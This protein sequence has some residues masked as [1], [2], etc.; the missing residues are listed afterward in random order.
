MQE[1][2]TTIVARL[3]QT[4]YKDEITKLVANNGEASFKSD[5]T[6]K[7][8]GSLENY[9]PPTP[10][11][12][13]VDLDAPARP[14]GF[15]AYKPL[16]VRFKW[17]NNYA[18]NSW[19]IDGDL[20]NL[21]KPTRYWTIVTDNAGE[22]QNRTEATIIPGSRANT[23]GGRKTEWVILGMT[24]LSQPK[25]KGSNG[26]GFTPQP[27]SAATTPSPASVP[28][29]NRNSQGSE[30]IVVNNGDERP[31][32]TIGPD[33]SIPSPWIMPLHYYQDKDQKLGRVSAIQ[34]MA[35]FVAS[36]EANV[37]DRKL[38]RWM[39]ASLWNGDAPKIEIPEVMEKQILQWGPQPKEANVV[40]EVTQENS[41]TTEAE[42]NE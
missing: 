33:D 37:Q 34:H 12:L 13:Q 8:L 19:Q 42:T 16:H 40:D 41:D 4:F 23:E 39:I 5:Y 6:G 32:G 9:P 24:I 30:A 35:T 22:V 1:S 20:N 15:T 26:N 7:F 38:F 18:E 27:A 2:I 29:P 21:V 3:P 10:F 36:A 25:P 17:Q 14:D 31:S 11:E 28:V